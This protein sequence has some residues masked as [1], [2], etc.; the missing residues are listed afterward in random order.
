M[1]PV[2]LRDPA[3]DVAVAGLALVLLQGLPLDVDCL[4]RHGLD[5]RVN[6]ADARV[7]PGVVSI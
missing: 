4:H 7:G 5:H 6:R 2:L 3:G 1:Q